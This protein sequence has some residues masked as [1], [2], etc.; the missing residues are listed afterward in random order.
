MIVKIF[1]DPNLVMYLSKGWSEDKLVSGTIKTLS[2]RTFSVSVSDDAT[3]RN[4]KGAIEDQEGFPIENQELRKG[5]TK[6]KDDNKTLA[7]YFVLNNMTLLLLVDGGIAPIQD[8]GNHQVPL[9]S[10]KTSAYDPTKVI[11]LDPE[12]VDSEKKEGDWW[13]A[14][15]TVSGPKYKGRLGQS[16]QNSKEKE[17]EET[18][19]TENS[20]TS[21]NTTTTTST[22]TPSTITTSEEK[23]EDKDKEQERLR[24]LKAIEARLNKK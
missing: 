6:L 10:T 19:K 17:K 11:V 1:T 24:R 7:D 15:G 18:S 12:E 16:S 21:E 13:K 23:Q 20:E 9:G 2:S 14:S 4:L 5:K 8:L 22:T 3:V